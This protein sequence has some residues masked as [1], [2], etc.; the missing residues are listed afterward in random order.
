MQHLRA[1]EQKVAARQ[2]VTLVRPEVEQT[3]PLP[4]AG[5]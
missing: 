4:T 1:P 3:G 5:A 2:F